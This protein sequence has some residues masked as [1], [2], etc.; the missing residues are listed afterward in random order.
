M[1]GGGEGV[2]A[3]GHEDQQPQC[4]EEYLEVSIRKMSNH[5]G[6]NILEFSSSS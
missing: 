2:R 1:G 4:A 5:A 3:R 6:P